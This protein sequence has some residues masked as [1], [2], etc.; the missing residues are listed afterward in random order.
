[1]G[2]SISLNCITLNS[3]TV[4]INKNT[5]DAGNKHDEFVFSYIIPNVLYH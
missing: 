2:T 3:V 5:W 1:M 4:I